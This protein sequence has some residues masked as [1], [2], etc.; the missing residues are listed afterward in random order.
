MFIQD[1]DKKIEDHKREIAKLEANRALQARKA[2]G[3]VNFSKAID[4]FCKEYEVSE[5]ELFLSQS[6]RFLPII[7][8]LSKHQPK[9]NLILELKTFFVRLAQRDDMSKK[10]PTQKVLG[11]RLEVGTYHNPKTGDFVEKIKRN[12]KMLDSWVAEFGFAMVQSWKV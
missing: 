8:T 1:I 6:K 10:T 11:P 2:E 5:E 4:Q 12:P 9:P 7:K 3:F